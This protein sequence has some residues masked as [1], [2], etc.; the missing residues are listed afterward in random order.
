MKVGK[1]R[2]V[3]PNEKTR[4]DRRRA[5]DRRALRA[6]GQGHARDPAPEDA[7][8][9]DLR[10]AGARQRQP[11]TI[12]GRRH[13]RRRA[14]WRETVQLDEILRTF[15]P[16]T[17][18]RVLHLA[19]PAGR[20]GARAAARRS[21]TRSATSRRSRRTPTTCCGCCACQ[22][23]ATRRLVRN[24]GEVFGALSERQGQLRAAD[25]QLQPRLGGD[26]AARRR[27]RGHVPRA[28]H[29]P[30]RGPHHDQ[31]LTEFAKNT[32]PLIDQLR[33]AARQL[34]PT[35]IGLDEL[36]PD[37]RGLFT[38]LDPLVAVSKKGLPATSQALNN[39]RPLLAP[40]RPVPAQFTPIVDYLGPLQARDRRVLRAT[41]RRPRRPSRR[42][43]P[44]GPIH[45]LRTQNP[46]NP[47]I[48]AAYPN[49]LSTNRSN[50]YIEPG[51]YNKL[52]SLSHLQT[53]G[54]YLCTHQPGAEPARAHR[55]AA[56]GRAG[57]AQLLRV[58]RTRRTTTRLRPA[59][60]RRRSGTPDHGG[61]PGRVP[62]PPAAALGAL[63]KLTA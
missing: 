52:A 12:A 53:F 60:R 15:D 19:R 22:S 33:P 50:P 55:R 42:Q 35:L 46:V 29:L 30:A 23:G 5:R 41:T 21:T 9:R 11:G 32:N 43:R 59:T 6:D 3:E 17:R 44:P 18:E 45:Y 63:P 4:A 61:A 49:R 24:T 13:A 37:L 31:R 7:A 2:K 1:V 25:P 58:R 16:K 39:T 38:D 34:S 36:A 28:A 54:S 47:E 20:G 48:M 51:G 8:G 40:A 26:G 27:A 14:R 56:G 57:R 10:G 62:A